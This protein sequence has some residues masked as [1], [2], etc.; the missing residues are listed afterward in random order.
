MAVHTRMPT[1]QC[2]DHRK[3]WWHRIW[4][5]SHWQ[6]VRQLVRLGSNPLL[7]V[8]SRMPR[9]LEQRASGDP[10]GSCN[11]AVRDVVRLGREPLLAVHPRLP[12]LWGRKPHRAAAHDLRLCQLVR[13]GPNQLLEVHA[14]VPGLHTG[15]DQLHEPD[16]QHQQHAAGLHRR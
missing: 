1:V 12:W 14:G 6:S 8:H 5:G 4:H 16:E 3:H 15:R 7:A 11:S 13:M 10:G 2:G 9:M